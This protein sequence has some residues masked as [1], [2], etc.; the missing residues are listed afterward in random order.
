MGLKPLEIL[1][2]LIVVV[3]LFGTTRLPQLGS[4]LGSAIRNFKKGFAGGDDVPE[5]DA[6]KNPG[7]LAGGNPVK[8]ANAPAQNPAPIKPS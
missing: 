3:L 2:I 8:D 6:Q 5:G 4:S 7:Q 1:L